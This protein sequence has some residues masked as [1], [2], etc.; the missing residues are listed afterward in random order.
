[1]EPA[2]PARLPGPQSPSHRPR[3]LLILSSITL[4]YGGMMLVSG[5]NGLRDPTWL[6]RRAVNQPLSPADE[7][8]VEEANAVNLPI[9]LAHTRAIRGYAAASM[10][11]ALLM[12]YAAAAT[13]SRDR[14]GRT[15]M[16]VAAWAGMAYHLGSLP[17]VVPIIRDC[18]AASEPLM[19]RVASEQLAAAAAAAERGGAAGAGALATP[20]AEPPP[21][22]EALAA[23]A[24][25]FIVALP[26]GGALAG[27][28]GSVLLIVFF[29][30]RRG[31][32]LY[33]LDAPTRAA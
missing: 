31:R 23:E 4:I 17:V 25:R 14:R 27:V 29:G 26:F 7:A 21:T 5:L 16:L 24:R 30:G 22:P 2:A 8:R 13:L 28:S 33:G 9:L 12:L 10:G 18:A 6:A 32:R 20:P 3:W 19:V 15:V 11:F 1:M